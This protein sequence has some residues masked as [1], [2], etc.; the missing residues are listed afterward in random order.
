VLTPCVQAV[1]EN[2]GETTAIAGLQRE[3]LCSSFGS[4][5]TTVSIQF[6]FLNWQI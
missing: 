4:S 5:H 1:P 3:A 2:A 6:G